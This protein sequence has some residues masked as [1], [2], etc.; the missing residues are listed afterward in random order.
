MIILLDVT[1]HCN[2]SLLIEI[3]L[4]TF[5]RKQ[6]KKDNSVASVESES[7]LSRVFSYSGDKIQNF[8]I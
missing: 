6:S 5:Y 2:P 8:H 4:V 1:V 3:A 7:M